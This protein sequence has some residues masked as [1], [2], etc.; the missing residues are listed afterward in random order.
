MTDKK[1]GK[2]NIQQP[3]A[4]A[5]NDRGIGGVGL[6]DQAISDSRPVICGK[7]WYCHWS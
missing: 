3:A 4:I 5:A 1:K 6:L 7:K 2:Q